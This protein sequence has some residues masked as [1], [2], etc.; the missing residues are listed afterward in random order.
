MEVIIIRVPEAPGGEDKRGLLE[1]E[2][3]AVDQCRLRPILLAGF[4]L[5][6]CRWR[7]RWYGCW[8]WCWSAIFSDFS[9][10]SD[11]ME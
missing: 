3:F 5:L 9:D 7:C 6:S 8:C 1:G 4:P 11:M 2:A 10:F